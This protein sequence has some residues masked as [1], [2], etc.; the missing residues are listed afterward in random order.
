MIFTGINH[1]NQQV[2]RCQVYLTE[3]NMLDDTVS[4]NTTD[5]VWEAVLDLS[6]ALGVRPPADMA[7]LIPTEDQ[8]I[9]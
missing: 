9:S 7:Q 2:T 5:T 4:V 1:I 3:S 6:G 8:K